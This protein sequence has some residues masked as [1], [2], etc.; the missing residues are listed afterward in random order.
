M[1]KENTKCVIKS[2]PSVLAHLV[3][4][5]VDATNKDG[6]RGMDTQGFSMTGGGLIFGNGDSGVVVVP[7]D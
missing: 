3:G 6:A 5:H 4:Q 2:A 1:I 7:K